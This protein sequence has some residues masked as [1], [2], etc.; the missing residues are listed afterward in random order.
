MAVCGRDEFLRKEK[1]L[2]C[3]QEIIEWLVNGL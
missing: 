2:G 1:I 3:P